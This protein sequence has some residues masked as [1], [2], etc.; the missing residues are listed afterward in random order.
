MEEEIARQ[1]AETGGVD[2]DISLDRFMN[3]EALYK[4]FLLKFLE[5]RSY[6]DLQENLSNNR[7]EA[8][9]ASAHTLKGL[10]GNLGLEKMFRL[11]IPMAEALR[12]G[13][14]E[15]AR[16]HWPDVSAQYAAICK[17]IGQ[18]KEKSA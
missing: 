18:L 1:L 13:K 12:N 17:V 3:N 6:A 2:L 7:V 5:D 4:K 8:S 16:R 14:M 11:L 10:S 9:F 15:E